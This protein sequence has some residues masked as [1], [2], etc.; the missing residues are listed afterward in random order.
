[1]QTV[2]GL[3]TLFVFVLGVLFANFISDF[4][5]EKYDQSGE[6]EKKSLVVT[7][8]VVIAIGITVSFIQSYALGVLAVVAFISVMIANVLSEIIKQKYYRGG[9]VEKKCIMTIGIIAILIVLF[10]STYN[11]A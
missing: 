6:F 5:H 10:L 4:I 3:L 1:M 8:S 9:V 7:A 11:S 2:I